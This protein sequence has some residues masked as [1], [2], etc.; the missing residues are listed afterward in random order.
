MVT[1]YSGFFL[2]FQTTRVEQR[3]FRVLKNDLSQKMEHTDHKKSQVLILLHLRNVLMNYVEVFGWLFLVGLMVISAGPT[4]AQDTVESIKNRLVFPSNKHFISFLTISFSFITYPIQMWIL[5]LFCWQWGLYFY[6][7]TTIS[8]CLDIDLS[9]KVNNG[10]S[11][12]MY[13]RCLVI[14]V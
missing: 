4:Q 2:G 5:E 11:A 10:T 14:R 13:F 9:C 12:I 3:T 1:D 8:T 7:L 6:Y